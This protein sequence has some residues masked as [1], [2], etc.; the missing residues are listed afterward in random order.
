MILPGDSLYNNLDVFQVN[1]LY[2][3]PDK[4]I[5]ELI[6][7]L[8]MDCCISV[9]VDLYNWLPHSVNWQKIITIIIDYWLGMTVI[10]KFFLL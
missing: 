3:N 4:I 8:N 9:L 2:I 6:S 5:E 7:K 10:D 1:D